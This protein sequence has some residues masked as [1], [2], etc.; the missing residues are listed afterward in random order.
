MMMMMIITNAS[1]YLAGDPLAHHEHVGQCHAEQLAPL[2]ESLTRPPE[3]A[4]VVSFVT[5]TATATT[6]PTTKQ[7]VVHLQNN[8]KTAYNIHVKMMQHN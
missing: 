8:H 7:V 4:E 5:H 6:T 1:F 3:A 2:G